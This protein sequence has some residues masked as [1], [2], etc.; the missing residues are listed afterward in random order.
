[1]LTLEFCYIYLK[2]SKVNWNDT[3]QLFKVS[4]ISFCLKK[5]VSLN[6]FVAWLLAVYAYGDSLQKLFNWF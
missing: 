1:M 5:P 4:A 3:S 2:N 6:K